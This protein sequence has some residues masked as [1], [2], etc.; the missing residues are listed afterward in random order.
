MTNENG[1]GEQVIA[2]RSAPTVFSKPEWSPNAQFI[3]YSLL[4]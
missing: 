3:A 2:T 4:K 1:T